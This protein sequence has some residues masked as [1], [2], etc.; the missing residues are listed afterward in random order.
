MQ[1][2]DFHYDLPEELIA[3]EPLAAR[4]DSRLLCL[5]GEHGRWRDSEFAQL[6]QCLRAGDLLVL[7]DTKVLP[8][9]L[10][11]RK[12]SGGKIEVMVERVVDEQRLLAII[13]A[14]KSPPIG[15]TVILG[16]GAEF[17]VVGR[18]GMLFEL[19]MSGTEPLLSFLDRIGQVPLPPYVKRQPGP[20]DRDRYQTV[21]ARVPGAV[22]APTAGLHFDAHALAEFAGRGIAHVFVTLHVGAG[23]FLPVR[24]KTIEEHLMHAERIHVSAEVCATVNQTRAAGGR[25]IAV[26]TTTLRTLEA[27]MISDQ[28]QPACGETRLFI[29]P[30]YRFR[31][32]DALVTNFH[33]PASTLLMLVCAFSGTEAT[34]AAYRHAVAA[35][36][37]FFSYGDAMFATRTPQ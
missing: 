33:L 13:K 37:R 19:T 2:R 29:Y 7:N 15:S 1:L 3:Q 14:S 32:V 8:A 34:L 26:G 6:A 21:Y 30:G 28:L 23:T 5:D 10:H 35:R 12:R 9:R 31:C 36:Y 24:C 17:E 27:A 4:R 20:Q 25:I 16:E 11:G 22:A 18:Q